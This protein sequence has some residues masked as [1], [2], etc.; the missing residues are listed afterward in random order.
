MFNASGEDA[1][2]LKRWRIHRNQ[3]FDSMPI[4][5]ESRLT[6]NKCGYNCLHVLFPCNFYTS[7]GGYIYGPNSSPIG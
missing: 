1:S 3:W 7:T 4:C 5:R 6:V 2:Q